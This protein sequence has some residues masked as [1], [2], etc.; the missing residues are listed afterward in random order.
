MRRSVMDKKDKALI[1]ELKSRIP[2]DIKK[3]L[4][5]LVV[6]GSRARGNASEYS[7]LDVV[8]LLDKKTAAIEKK[9]EDSVYELMW[10]HDFKPI[11]SVKI[12][13]ESRFNQ[14]VHKGFSFYRN[15]QREGVVI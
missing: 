4:K 9:I 3:N 1:L 8:I 15:I 5:R 6:F 13:A 7:D 11:I 14:A 10:E 2:S 12:F